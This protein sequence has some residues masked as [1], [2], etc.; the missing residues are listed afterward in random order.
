LIQRFFVAT[1]AVLVRAG[2][3]TYADCHLA[4]RF[5]RH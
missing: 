4:S 2:H 1:C 3:S 5:L